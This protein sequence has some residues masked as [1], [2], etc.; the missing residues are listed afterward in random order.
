MERLSERINILVMPTDIC[1]MNCIYCF[2]HEHHENLGKIS[3]DTI[4]KLYEITL[5]KYKQVNFIWHGGEPLVMGLDFYKE[6]INMQKKY[7]NC[8]VTNKIQSNLTLLTDEYLD[9]F[10]ENDFGIGS[11][12]D[13]ILNEELRGNSEQILNARQKIVE[14]GKS[15]GFIMVV[16]N[17]NIDTLVES[18]EFFK[19]IN[20]NFTINPYVQS[21]D[22]PNLEL[23]L[24]AEHT[25]EKLIELYNLWLYDKDCNIHIDYFERII[26]FLIS[27]K[28][29]VCKY[30]SCLGKWAGIRY[31]GDI[32]P[33]NRY[34]PLEYSY[35]NVYEYDDLNQ[36]FM[37]KGFEKILAE[38]I[39]RRKKCSNCNVFPMCNGG[40]N[41]VAYNEN[42]ISEKGGESCK[43]LNG[44]FKYIKDSF[45]NLKCNIDET[46]INPQV[47][48][49]LNSK[50][51]SI[52]HYDCHN[53]TKERK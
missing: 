15:C 36:G 29:T 21:K 5:G 28:K 2:H 41:N 33:C 51:N 11:S 46:T 3:I 45:K 42:G 50:T 19:S 18:Y 23:E 20:A 8:K 38:A 9:F 40:C 31:N 53:D 44:I 17:K 25:I 22:N 34:F 48:R 49:M 26:K 43:I 24:K 47:V 32:V 37:S 52:S 35:G 16:S 6:V 7:L 4:N 1:N 39:D 12:F 27:G 30:S 14:R 10:I 13:G